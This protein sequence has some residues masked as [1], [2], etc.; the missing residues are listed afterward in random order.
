MLNEHD[1]VTG[2][3]KKLRIAVITQYFQPEIFPINPLVNQLARLGHSIEVLTG[4]P[5]YP[6]GRFYAGYS[7]AGPWREQMGQ[8]VVKR[9]PMAPRGHGGKFRLAAN[10]FSFAFFSTLLAPWR[11]RNKYDVILV[12]QASP[13]LA[14]LPALLLS[15]LRGIPIA[16]WVQDLWPESLRVAKIRSKLIY[17][18]MDR[19]M[20]LT[21]ANSSAVMIQSRDFRSHALGY[22]VPDHKIHYVPNWADAGVLG[23]ASA[24]PTEDSEEMPQGFRIIL[25]GNLGAAQDL[26]TLVTACGMLKGHPRARVIVVGDGRMRPWLEA[27]ITR[28]EL[29][30]ILTYLGHRPAGRMG[31][32]FRQSDAALLTLLPDPVLDRTIPSR[33]Q[34]YLTHGKPV[35][36]ALDGEARRIVESSG[37]GIGV[38]A[39]SPVEL[40]NAIEKMASA[41]SESIAAMSLAA[42]TLSETEFNPDRIVPAVED[43]LRNL[44]AKAKA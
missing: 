7:L 2:K 11:L 30:P 31:S 41:S 44:A 20:R 43:L 1:S 19:L 13:L 39:L 27:E 5:N 33:L 10:Y 34:A 25:A 23:E 28:R 42:R 8:I 12:C 6:H 26:E 22:G 32:Y 17:R 35:I 18:M 24:N 36:A 14:V 21:Y 9:V 3:D 16:L 38:P 15:R 4:L 29:S 37:A 40:K